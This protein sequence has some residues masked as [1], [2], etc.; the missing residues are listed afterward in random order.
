MKAVTILFVVVAAIGVITS[1]LAFFHLVP[2][3][4]ATWKYFI[5]GLLAERQLF[6]ERGWRYRNTALLC[7][8]IGSILL[9][10]MGLID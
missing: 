3:Q 9:L 8:A 6:T 2:G 7:L 10:V 5:R 4:N 1:L